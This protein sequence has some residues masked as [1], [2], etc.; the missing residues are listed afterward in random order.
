MIVIFKT[1]GASFSAIEVFAFIGEVLVRSLQLFGG[2]FYLCPR[3]LG[4]LI[5]AR[6][7]CLRLSLLSFEVSSTWKVAAV[8]FLSKTLNEVLAHM[9]V[10][11]VRD[12]VAVLK[13]VFMLQCWYRNRWRNTLLIMDTATFD[14]INIAG[15]VIPTGV[16]T[17][18]RYPFPA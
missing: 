6:C 5:Q 17:F 2:F 18:I 9:L 8:T 14:S 3:V 4:A 7:M 10:L 13:D 12:V 15:M 16:F 11:R 1:F